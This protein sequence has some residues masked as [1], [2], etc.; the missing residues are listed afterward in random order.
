MAPCIEQREFRQRM[1]CTW[2][3][4]TLP[5]RSTTGSMQMLVFVARRSGGNL[6]PISCGSRISLCGTIVTLQR[7][8]SWEVSRMST[9]LVQV[10]S[11]TA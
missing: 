8:K 11:F 7:T 5:P 2:E 6:W 10:I 4:R 1:S 9:L 3:A